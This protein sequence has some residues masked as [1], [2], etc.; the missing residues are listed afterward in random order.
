MAVVERSRLSR[1]EGFRVQSRQG[2]AGWV[3]ETWLDPAGEATAVAVLLV[4]GRRGLLLADDVEALLP[5]DES[6]LVR[7]G[8]ELLELDAPRVERDADGAPRSR[9]TASWRTTGEVLELP[10]PPGLLRRA[11]PSSRRRALAPPRRKPER[12]LW[13]IVALLYTA[14]AALV[15]LVIALAFVVADLVTGRAY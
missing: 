11:R 6:I 3:E 12:P 2:L 4:D 1:C 8:G 14:I 7:A 10:A 13:Q 9:V 15:G 5:D